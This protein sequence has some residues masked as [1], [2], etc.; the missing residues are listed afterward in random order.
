MKINWLWDTRLTEARVKRILQN[1]K[2]P[3]FYIY[4]EKLFSRVDD[5]KDAFR[6]VS[7]DAFYR[8]WPSIK[9]RIE[10]DAWV[11]NRAVFWQTIYDRVKREI[12]EQPIGI[13]ERISIAQQIKNLR[14]KM[15]Y[16]Q[17]EMAEKLGVIQ[18]YVSKLE[19]GS[20]NLTIDTLKRIAQVLGKKLAIQF[21]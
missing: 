8:K 6:Y 16:T 2:D 21:G 3:R 11:K 4:A 12:E 10:K 9:Q 19:A 13:S 7:K 18:Q 5:P 1:E 20:E 17:E 14:V 15:G